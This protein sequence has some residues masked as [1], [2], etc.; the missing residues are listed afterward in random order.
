[1]SVKQ[2]MGHNQFRN[3]IGTNR[4]HQGEASV[5]Q[6]FPE[7]VLQKNKSARDKGDK[8]IHTQTHV[9]VCIIHK[10]A[11]SKLTI[12]FSCSGLFLWLDWLLHLSL[13]HGFVV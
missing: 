8:C 9:Y 12:F 13:H 3:K 4:I 5:A 10:S 6:K 11:G 7:N 1:M 2:N